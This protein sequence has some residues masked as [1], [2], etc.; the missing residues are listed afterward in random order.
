MAIVAYQVDA[1]ERSMDEKLPEILPYVLDADLLSIATLHRTR[2]VARVWKSQAEI[3]LAGLPSVVV[4]GGGSFG[5]GY[6]AVSTYRSV[7]ALDLSRMA[8]VSMPPMKSA[9]T[10]FSAAVT[11]DASGAT[12]IVVL[13]G[14]HRRPTQ[15]ATPW[16]EGPKAELMN[17]VE[18]FDPATA[19]WECLPPLPL[20]LAGAVAVAPDGG[21]GEL[22]V[23]GGGRKSKPGETFVVPEGAP[24]LNQHLR[25]YL[26]GGP[27]AMLQTAMTQ[28][29]HDGS[30]ALPT[31]GGDLKWRP[32]DRTFALKT[33]PGESTPRWEERAPFPPF[34][35]EWMGGITQPGVVGVRGG[36]VVAVGDEIVRVGE[37]NYLSI[38]SEIFSNQVSVYRA[39]SDEWLPV[40]IT[41]A[42]PAHPGAN[43][44]GARGVV[45]LGAS[46]GHLAVLGGKT[47]FSAVGRNVTA[48]RSLVVTV[49]PSEGGATAQWADRAM[50]PPLPVALNGF[51][52][53]AV[54]RTIFVAGGA[55]REIHPLHPMIHRDMPSDSA[56]ML[57]IDTNK[58]I[59]LPTSLRLER[60]EPCLVTAR[61]LTPAVRAFGER[62][63]QGQEDDAVKE[64]FHRAEMG[65]QVGCTIA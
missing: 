5:S 9:C 44:H 27:Y 46:D 13:G 41:T 6:A 21:R 24:A 65:A 7:E 30:M 39:A 10:D 57:D 33:R 50:L 29:A 11:K 47:D 19:D 36:A 34:D 28:T 17:G 18:A 61:V 15:V 20:S 16:C 51:G 3:M 43:V 56:F 59:K 48:V 12:K 58:W 53:C 26:S 40:E 31:G 55:T 49:S 35:R 54:G 37:Y 63:K 14:V 25:T 23:F 38:P 52:C 42:P 32:S 22:L 45:A 1:V 4:L 64:D 62:A 8:F 60:H 2:R